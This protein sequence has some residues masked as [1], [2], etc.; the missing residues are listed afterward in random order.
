MEEQTAEIITAAMEQVA[1]RAGDITAQVFDAYFARSKAAAD[2]M[3][4]MDEH[5]RGRM[6]DQVLLLLMESEN[7]ELQSYLEFETYN[8]I[9]YGATSEMYQS[10][11]AAVREVTAAIL[12]ADFSAEIAAALDERTN[13]LLAAIDESARQA[14]MKHAA[15]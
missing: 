9:A 11:M 7:A 3:N 2:V 5:M 12:G 1:E 10:L 4:H 15:G 8:H 13:F 6:M 14:E